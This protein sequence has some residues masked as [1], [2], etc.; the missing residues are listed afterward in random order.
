[1]ESYAYK[2]NIAKEKMKL[3]K[4]IEEI[5]QNKSHN[6]EEVLKEYFKLRISNDKRIDNLKSVHNDM[7]KSAQQ[8]IK[9]LK[10][11]SIKKINFNVTMYKSNIK[12]DNISIIS[13]KVF[14]ALIGSFDNN[15]YIYYENN[16]EQILNYI[17]EINKIQ[18]ELKSLN[19][20]L[21]SIIN[22]FVKNNNIK[23]HKLS[24]FVSLYQEMKKDLNFYSNYCDNIE[25][26]NKFQEE[27][28]KLS[29]S[30]KEIFLDE[31]NKIESIRILNKMCK[32]KIEEDDLEYKRKMSK[33][34]T[35]RIGNNGKEFVL[36][37]M[38]NMSVEKSVEEIMLN[39]KE[40]KEL[41]E[42]LCK[43]QPKKEKVKKPKLTKEERAIKKAKEEIGMRTF[44]N[45]FKGLI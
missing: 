1:M 7:K 26:F 40:T 21:N 18:S 17:K 6:S 39:N 8:K 38:S 25:E 20:E 37:V 36:N 19:K 34:Y 29:S 22:T 2:L 23:T 45:M 15:N 13:L 27:K 42:E 14:E 32:E 44:N 9:D 16:K 28:N 5:L 31:V 10:N 30:I 33:H 43:E 3:D 4:T 24:H 35:P 41:A 11:I 12:E